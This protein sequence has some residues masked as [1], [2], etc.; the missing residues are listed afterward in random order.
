MSHLNQSIPLNIIAFSL[1]HLPSL[2]ADFGAST[3][4]ECSQLSQGGTINQLH[5]A[6]LGQLVSAALET[7]D[8]CSILLLLI[9][10][11][12]GKLKNK[13]DGTRNKNCRFRQQYLI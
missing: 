13:N 7:F 10:K 6:S 2:G 8:N 4:K 5:L 9:A 3:D 12:S 11:L 1:T